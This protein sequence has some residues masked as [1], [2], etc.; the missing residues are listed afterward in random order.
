MARQ[1]HGGKRTILTLVSTY[2][3]FDTARWWQEA[4]KHSHRT[5]FERDRARVV[6]S[7]AL[8][9]LGAKT[10][11]LGPGSDD[12]V[13][14]RLT[15]SLEVAQVGRE[16]GKN[17]GCDPDIVDAAC[18]SHDLGHPPFGHNGEAALDLVATS[19]GGFEGNAQTLRLLTRLEPK[20]LTDDGTP[21]G[22]NLTRAS[23][24]AAIKYPWQAQQAPTLPDGSRSPK[25]G[26]YASDLPVFTWVREGAPEGKL[27]LEAQVMDLADD[28]SYSVHDVEDGIV[29]GRIPADVLWEE[30]HFGTILQHISDWYQPQVTE[31]ELLEAMRRLRE[32]PT[33]PKE[34]TGSRSSLAQL[35]NLTSDLIGRFCLAAA[36]A[37][38]EEFGSGPLIRYD[39][40]LRIPAEIEAE[41]LVLKGLAATFVMAPRE[42]EP[43]FRQQRTMLAELVEVLSERPQQLEPQFAQDYRAGEN[44]AQRLRAVVDQVASLTDASAKAMHD[45]LCIAPSS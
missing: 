30:A 13:R 39:A 20:T 36:A 12:F 16:L 10:Q 23:L 1:H 38:R 8:R 26:V 3:S 4:P 27:C 25:F 42:S 45:R 18:L 11:V 33:W 24:D 37:T 5:A 15:H 19:I 43:V 14:T 7:S 29:G 6:H 9:R 31:A 21:V 35:K 22:L 2:G 17:L 44:D 32:L 28:V 34:F 40:D 41:I